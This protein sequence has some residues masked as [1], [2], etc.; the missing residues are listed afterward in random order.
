MKSLQ[1]KAH[2]LL[3]TLSGASICAA[4]ALVASM[5]F[6]RFPGRTLV[7]VVF[8]VL[9]AVLAAYFGLA[10]GIL[11]TL[12]AAFV[13]A[14]WLYLPIGSLAVQNPGARAE[15]AWLLLGGVS[16]SFLLAP[17]SHRR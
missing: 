4:G 15:I 11:G 1:P 14:N 5:V 8:V 13:F 16:L 6:Q 3:L 2:S 12:I 17:E 9:I 10:A 7:P